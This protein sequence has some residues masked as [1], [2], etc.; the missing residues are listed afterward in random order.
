MGLFWIIIKIL[1]NSIIKH[2]P[3]IYDDFPCFF[4][5][6]EG[7]RVIAN[8]S[9][10]PDY[11]FVSGLK[12]RWA[13]AGGLLTDAEYRGKGLATLL[14]KN[15][16][17]VL[18]RKNIGWGGVFSNLAALHIFGKLGLTIPGY[19]NRYVFLKAAK[20]FLRYYIKNKFFLRFI[21]FFYQKTV[22]IMVGAINKFSSPAG[23]N[24]NRVKIDVEGNRNKGFSNVYY[25]TKYHFNH[26]FSKIKWRMSGKNEMALYV[27]SNEQSNGDI[28]YFIVKSRTVKEPFVGKYK[29][30]GLMTLMD[31]GCFDPNLANYCNILKEAFQE[32]L[33]SDA[34][35]LEIISSFRFM[36]FL[37]K[38][39]GFIKL[40][41]GMPFTF[42]IPPGWN[43]EEDCK[44]IWNWPLTHFCGD[45]FSFP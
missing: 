41:K 25:F 27:V 18:K 3:D 30:F 33:Q 5:L 15:M 2:C 10:L 38:R 14:V 32:F 21:D 34:E 29:D 7:G 19:A 26:S 20:S 8:I 6:S 13:W 40:G 39:R 16:V 23:M 9:A 17:A 28:G 1:P 42:V 11:L 37:L 43:L 44:D 31:Y 36:N 35:V 24:G 12:H 22:R 45:A 4:Y